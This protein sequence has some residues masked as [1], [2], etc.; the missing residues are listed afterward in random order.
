MG[1]LASL[2][3]ASGKL[4]GAVSVTRLDGTTRT[5]PDETAAE[6]ALSGV[7]LEHRRGAFFEIGAKTDKD[8]ASGA[9]KD[10]K[11]K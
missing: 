1:R 9:A 3:K 7:V 4:K 11:K 2:A 6:A 5:F 10:P 8:A